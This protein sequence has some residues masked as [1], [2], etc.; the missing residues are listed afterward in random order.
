MNDC[1]IYKH[2]TTSARGE[3]PAGARS[4]SAWVV[5]KRAKLTKGLWVSGLGSRL[6][7]YRLGFSPVNL[8]SLLRLPSPR[9]VASRHAAKRLL[10]RCFI[11][12][13]RNTLHFRA[14]YFTQEQTERHIEI[15][16]RQFA[17]SVRRTA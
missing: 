12:G 4:L 13:N 9:R 15:K 6:K 8:A 17:V 3:H 11:L 14:F 1:V 16:R 7:G 2:A 10:R 5:W